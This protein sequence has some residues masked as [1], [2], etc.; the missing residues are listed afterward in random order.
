MPTTV[1]RLDGPRLR[2]ALAVFAVCLP[3]VGSTAARKAGDHVLRLA[4]GNRTL[5]VEACTDRIVRVSF[6]P[7]PSFSDRTTLAAAPKR[8]G[9][10]SWTQQTS[11][12]VTTISTRSLKVRVDRRTGL[13]RFADLHGKEILDELDRTLEPA[14][15]Q[16]EQTFHVRQQWNAQDEA[17]FGLG[18]HQL[19]LMNIKGYD[20]DLWQHNAT[21]AVPFL[22]SSRGYGI[23][24][25]NTSYSR[26]GDIRQPAFM[27]SDQL[28]DASGK[29]GGLTGTYFAGAH[30]DRLVATRVDPRIDI[31]V[32]GG[33]PEANRRIHPDLPQDGDISVRWEGSIRA[34]ETGD[35]LF[36]TYSNSGIRLWIDDRLVVDRWRQGWLPWYDV[37]RARFEAGRTYRIKL[38]WSKDQGIETMRL[39]WKTP[40]SSAAT[41]LWSEV[42]DGIDYYFVYG[43][44]LDDVVGGYRTITGEAPM[45]PRWTFGFWQCRERYK[46]A[47]ESLD[48]VRE[49]RRRQ[50]PLDAIVQ[51]WQYW[52]LDAWGSHAFDAARFPDPDGWIR[53]IHDEHA[54]LM[55]SVWGKYYPTTENAKAMRA[56]GQLWEQP[57]KEGLKDWLGFPYTFY[58]AFNAEGGKAFWAQVNTA[59]FKRGVDAWWMDA[60]EPDIAQPM[61]TLERQH[62]LMQPT[63]MG[64]ASRVLNAYSL[65][66]AQAIFE[67]QRAAAPDQRVFILTR[68]AFAG[69]QRYASAVWSGDITSSWGAFKAQ[70]PAGL[71]FSLS[72]VPYWTTDIG[73]FDTPPKFATDKQTPEAAEE[74]RE[75]NARWFEFGTFCPLTRAHGQFPFREPWNIAPDDHPA[76]AT[77]AKFIRL[78]Y[79]LLPYVYSLAGQITKHHG[80]MLRPLVMDFRSDPKVYDISDAFMFGPALL[81][82]PVTDYKARSRSV[83]L[84][85]GT[86]YDFWSGEAVAGGRAIDLTVPYDSIP[87]HV[88]A[89][90][91]LPIGPDVQYTGEKPSDPITVYVYAGANGRFDLYEDDGA[92]FAYEKGAASEIPFMWTDAART[93][94]IA[95]RQGSFPGMLASRTF[96]VIVVDPKHAAGAGGPAATGRSISYDGHAVTVRF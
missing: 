21:V 55:I 9:G 50:I 60:T 90:A 33:T 74:W 62:E 63:A 35:H 12:G 41:S 8:C 89:G 37:A 94:T 24:W 56:K 22:V 40:S 80:T 61:P 1:R 88:R 2:A 44:D 30:F 27:P 59:L 96:N 86:W 79:R 45:M 68:S 32:P 95:P 43:P 46:T 52:P 11:G 5:T 64:S 65:V 48:V 49:F 4:V 69:Q 13:V 38:E 84:P 73:G 87:V 85:A 75:L 19:G 26:F 72:G 57:L 20:L 77:I 15:V 91:I 14:S 10:A 81:V 71:G 18:Q 58:D 28:L 51:D 23:L 25:D 34:T 17:L 29:P 47:Q 3:A 6:A 66:N 70:I 67:G 39:Q 54:K 7:D 76:Y 42:G 53:N 93:L 92:S 31:E 83:Y 82:S 36:T 16:G 78:R